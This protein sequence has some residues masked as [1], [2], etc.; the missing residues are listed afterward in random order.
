MAVNDLALLARRRQLLDQLRTST[1]SQLT[2][3]WDSLDNYTDDTR[4]LTLA[5]PV[6]QAGQQRAAHLTIAS[7]EAILGTRL[8]FDTKTILERAKIDPTQPFIALANALSNKLEFAAAVDAGR[9][10]AEA[11]GESAVTF[12]ARAANGAAESH[13]SGWSRVPDAGA[14]DWCQTVAGQTYHTAD[15]ASFGHLRCACDVVP[16]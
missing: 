7:L 14:C 9:A 8:A 10:R 4:W 15:S 6:L 3:I 5:S 13:V 2:R 11:V 16:A 12:A 1:S